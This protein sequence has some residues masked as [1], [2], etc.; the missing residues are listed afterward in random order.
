MVFTPGLLFNNVRRPDGRRQGHQYI[1][2][3][4]HKIHQYLIT[5]MSTSQCKWI[6]QSIWRMRCV[7][8]TPT[9]CRFDIWSSKWHNAQ[10]RGKYRCCYPH[11]A[12]HI[13]NICWTLCSAILTCVCVC[14]FGAGQFEQIAFALAFVKPAMKKRKIVY[15]SIEN[16]ENNSKRNRTLCNGRLQCI[17]MN[18]VKPVLQFWMCR[19][20]TS[21]L[22]V[23]SF[24]LFST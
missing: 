11:V 21:L 24:F 1:Y 3:C 4:S 10:W 19:L 22:L 6:L 17:R 12:W 5:F 8:R 16:A 7:R 14:V 20:Y 2:I 18:C 13:C 23:G 15:F 9:A